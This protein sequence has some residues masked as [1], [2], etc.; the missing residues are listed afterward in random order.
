MKY[1]PNPKQAL[2][3]EDWK[4]YEADRLLSTAYRMGAEMEKTHSLK[5]LIQMQRDWDRNVLDQKAVD[6]SGDTK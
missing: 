2:T 1:D 6:N 4:D 3:P 5:H